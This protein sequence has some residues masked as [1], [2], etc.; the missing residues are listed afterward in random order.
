MYIKFE[1]GVFEIRKK[2]G[3]DLKNKVKGEPAWNFLNLK[4]TTN[5]YVTFPLK[6]YTAFAKYHL[7]LFGFKAGRCGA[8]R[9][10]E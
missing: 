2:E 8:V 4:L 10:C 7:C 9:I 6:M 1:V 5:K 3:E